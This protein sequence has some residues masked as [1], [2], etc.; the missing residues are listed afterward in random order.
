[1]EFNTEVTEI[2]KTHLKINLVGYFDEFSTLPETVQYQNYK[3]LEFDFRRLSF[4]NS[5]GIKQ[6]INYIEELNLYPEINIVFTHCPPIIIGQM[7]LISDFLPKNS[8][9]RSLYL[10]VFCQKCSKTMLVFQ[11]VKDIN[12]DDFESLA[13]K[14]EPSECNEFPACKKNFEL[15]MI[16]HQYL[17]FR[18]RKG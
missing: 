13:L 14:A 10:P 12:D 2:D 9:V 4:L 7:N 6:W 3:T 18:N 11:E 5:G 15:D 8:D 1:M 16:P 17:E